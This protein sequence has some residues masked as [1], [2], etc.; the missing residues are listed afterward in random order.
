MSPPVL[1]IHG[2]LGERMD[3][4]R[5]WIRPGVLARTG[6]G[7]ARSA[8]SG[9]GHE[10]VIVGSSRECHRPRNERA[11]VGGRRLQRRVR[12]GPA[13]AR[14]SAARG[15][16]RTGLARH[17]R[18]S[19]RRPSR[20]TACCA[21]VGWG[22]VAWRRRRPGEPRVVASALRGRP[23]SKAS[24]IRVSASEASTAPPA[25]AR[26]NAGT[27]GLIESASRSPITTAAVRMIA[28]MAQI[29]TTKRR[30]RPPRAWP[31]LR[32]GSPAGLTRRWRRARR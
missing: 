19:P 15:P 5:F 31:P 1:L 9:P 30:L 32:P 24:G 12:R 27:P 23:C 8:R 2:G 21:P 7:R 17:V 11:D 26:A 14:S 3:A 6:R 18:R 4:E 29:T 16:P 28:V 13:G 22:D 10:P 20:A 25:R